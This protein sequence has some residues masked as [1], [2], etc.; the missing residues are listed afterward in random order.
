[1]R[2]EEADLQTNKLLDQN[3]VCQIVTFMP[4][5]AILHFRLNNAWDG[6]CNWLDW[7]KQH[8]NPSFQ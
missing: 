3:H 4:E 6:G 1:M 8:G 5:I 7:V 2:I